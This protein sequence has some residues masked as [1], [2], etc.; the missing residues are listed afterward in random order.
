[1]ECAFC[2]CQVH[3]NKTFHKTIKTKELHFCC[4]KCLHAF[5]EQKEK[6]DVQHIQAPKTHRFI[7]SFAGGGAPI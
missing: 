2:K 1:M 7:N 5:V 3:P 4:M 6:Q